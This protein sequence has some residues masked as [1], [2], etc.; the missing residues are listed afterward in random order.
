M[1]FISPQLRADTQSKISETVMYTQKKLPRKEKETRK[2]S[3][4]KVNRATAVRAWRPIAKISTANQPL[5]DFL[6]MI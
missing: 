2:P 6:S 1:T 5:C 4:R 3:W